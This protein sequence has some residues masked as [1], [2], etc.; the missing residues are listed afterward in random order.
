MFP[1]AETLTELF[2]GSQRDEMNKQ[3]D[4]G[5]ETEYQPD[6]IRRKAA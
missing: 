2:S 1:E 3:K 4:R 6:V 5:R